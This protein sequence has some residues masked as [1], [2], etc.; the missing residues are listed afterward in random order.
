MPT[1]VST[2]QITIADQ[3]DARPIT[4][5][6]G[7]SGATQQVFTQDES[8]TVYTPDWATTNLTLTA[9]VYVGSTTNAAAQLSNRKWA[10][11]VGGTSLGSGTTYVINTNLAAT[12]SVVYYFE[13]DY[14]DPVTGLVTKVLA[15][16]SLSQVKT[17]TNAVFLQVTGQNA[18]LESNTGVKNT[19]TLT[20]DLYRA[21]GIDDSGITYRWYQS[22]HTAADQ[23]D[24]NL[25]AVTTKYGFQDTAAR[26]A[27]RAG[28]V[29]Q[30][31]TGATAT[32]AISTANI[33]DG[34]WTDLKA[35]TISE[36]AIADIGL[37]KVEAKDS[38]GAVYQQFFTVY[39][40]S[41]NYDTQ[42]I[43]SS[44]DKLQNGI[45]S[46]T[47]YARVFDGSTEVTNL[48]GWSFT[49]Y[50]YDRNGKRAA[51]IDT[52][53]TAV[54]GGRDITANTAV[55]SAAFSVSYSGTAIT[56]A[57]GD[58]VKLVTSGGSAEYFEVAT[59]SIASPVS[60]K[61]PAS[62]NAW[63]SWTGPASATY[64]AAGKLYACTSSGVRTVNGAS[65]ASAA[66]ITVTGDEIDGK[67][68]I[69]CE[70]NRP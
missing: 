38:S 64:F 65:T 9:Y 26:A 47:I 52:T 6:I 8:T 41:D 62:V 67:G 17:G 2:G 53:K 21:A 69:T 56:F 44:G 54:A 30:Y 55:A 10:T 1:L 33:P 68:T 28:V 40:V 18:I 24:G 13:G 59:A 20:A 5:F 15:Q 3:N 39:D 49:Y 60:L 4:S 35:I 37:F 51:F 46:T 43:S 25:T 27:N 14:T 16:I 34:G 48:T 32:A 66:T 45:G 61:S 29:G 31:Q 22:P 42:L 19:V 57:A 7:A 58:I 12:G 23:I 70:A 36:T 11:S 50:F 63:L